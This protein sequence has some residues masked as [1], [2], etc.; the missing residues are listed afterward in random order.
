LEQISKWKKF[1][2]CTKFESKQISEF[3]K[4]QNS[5]FEKCY[6]FEI[7]EKYLNLEKIIFENV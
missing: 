2:I 4:C 6:D 5:K 1:Q 3:E 7:D